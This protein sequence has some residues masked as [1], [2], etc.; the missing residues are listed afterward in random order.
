MKKNTNNHSH[1]YSWQLLKALSIFLAMLTLMMGIT[2]P[3]FGQT[4]HETLTQIND[5]AQL[6]G[7]DTAAHPDASYEPGAS[8]ITSAIFFALD[9]F[10]YLIGTIAVIIIMVSGIRLITSVKN[11]EDVATK[12]KENI[13]YAVMGLIVI[14]LADVMV[15]KVFFGEYG[16]VYRSQTDVQLAAERGVEQLVGIYNFAE[17]FVGAIA[18]LMIVIAGFSLVASAGKEESITKAKKQIMW[19][20]IGLMLIGISEFAVKDVFFPEKGTQ[21]PN[22]S[23]ASLLIMN[24]TNF[25]SGFMASIAI[26]L[27]MYGG[28]LYVIDLGKE[29]QTAKAKKVFLGATIGLVVAMAAYGLVHTVIKFEPLKEDVIQQVTPV[30]QDL[31]LPTGS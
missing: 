24:I 16:E 25:V 12:Q 17:Y 21:L 30:G 7:F 13:K 27:Y 2:M 6:P 26:A 22:I 8:N 15:K 3:A 29:E 31:G 23:K 1:F 18:V 20:V 11:V 14:M 10:K 19:A 4:L 5:K 28:Y 9:L